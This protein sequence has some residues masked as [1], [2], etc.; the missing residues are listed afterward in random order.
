[1]ASGRRSHHRTGGMTYSMADSRL[2]RP[3]EEALRSLQGASPLIK[4][5]DQGRDEGL[6][7]RDGPQSRPVTGK[8]TLQI[9]SPG[10]GQVA[11]GG[12]E[13]RLAGVDDDL[14]AALRVFEGDDADVGEVDLP[15]IVHPY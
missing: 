15:R 7:G 2:G 14:L 13:G 5:V 6:I 1:M 10:G 4:E 9:G 3:A 11:K 12:T 8:Q